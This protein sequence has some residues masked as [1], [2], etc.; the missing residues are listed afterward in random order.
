MDLGVH[1]HRV[2]GAIDRVLTTH[3]ARYAEVRADMSTRAEAAW[4]E[5]MSSDPVAASM[6][7]IQDEQTARA[8][9]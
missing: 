2:W 9:R 8:M 6:P 5:W 7:P 1:L 4:V 3:H